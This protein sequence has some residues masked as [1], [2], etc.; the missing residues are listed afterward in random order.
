MPGIIETESVERI[1]FPMD[2]EYFENIENLRHDYESWIVA[3]GGESSN[4]SD[5]KVKFLVASGETMNIG[6]YLNRLERNIEELS[7][8]TPLRCLFWLEEKL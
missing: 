6:K 3:G 4:I 8:E 2:F 5:R 1:F 7:L